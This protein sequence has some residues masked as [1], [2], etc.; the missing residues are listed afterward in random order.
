CREVELVATKEEDGRATVSPPMT[1]AIPA[2]ATNH[3]GNTPEV[4]FTFSDSMADGSAVTCTY[5]RS[6]TTYTFT[7][8]SNGAAAGSLATA[9]TLDLHF[10]NAS[11]AAKNPED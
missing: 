7:L 4:V 2:T 6:G 10:S 8:C 9:D 5:D 1:F 11:D 3:Q